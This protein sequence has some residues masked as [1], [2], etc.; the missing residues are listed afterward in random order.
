MT[1]PPKIAESLLAAGLADDPASLR[2][3]PLTGG[4]SSDIWQVIGGHRPMCV[5][6]ARSQL[7]VAATWEVPVERNHFEAE[8]LRVV[9]T[10]VPGFA[11]ELLAEDEALGLIVLPF[12]DPA[13][14]TLWKPHLLAGQVDVAVARHVGAHLG[15]LARAT[16]GRR[17]LAQRFDTTR[18]FHELRLDPYFLE[19]ARRHPDLAPELTELAT[20]TASRREALVHGDV[21]PKNVL[22]NGDSASVI[23]DAECA[24]YGDPAFDLA[25]ALNH[26]LLKSV[27]RPDAAGILRSAIE[28]LLEGRANADTPERAEAVQSRATHLLPGLL[29]AR[30]D[31]KSPVEYITD[32]EKKTSIR[33]VARQFLHAPAAHPL[34]IA[35]ALTGDTAP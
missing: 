12:F 8:F 22:V 9:G 33:A 28:A 16:R 2:F 27:H 24:W 3:I 20:S 21:S 17:D 4:V 32:L 10:E 29:L 1:P 23:L 13:E 35:R 15:R 26:L 14:W 25:F 34:E 30:I 6:R 19:C 18:L 7:A 31:G 5:K 11:P